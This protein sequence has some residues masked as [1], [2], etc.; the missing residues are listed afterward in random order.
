MRPAPPSTEPRCAVAPFGPKHAFRCLIMANRPLD[1]EEVRLLQAFADDVASGD[2]W[3]WRGVSG[4]RFTDEFSTRFL[5]VS[6]DL[7]ELARRDYVTR[8]DVLDPARKN[9]FYLIRI[10]G[11]GADY[12]AG[13]GGQVPPSLP[14]PGELTRVDLESLFIS[15]NSWE[16]LVALCEEL[17]ADDW[18]PAERIGTRI[19]STFHQN[20]GETL[21]A[22]GLAERRPIEGGASRV[23][24]GG[25]QYRATPLGRTARLVDGESSE[26][27]VQIRVTGLVRRTPSN[28]PER[29]SPFTR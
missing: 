10:S 14:E 20:D 23:P 25:R 26:T 29:R 19:G 17:D 24:R 7:Q 4:W 3:T 21:I 1:P 2:G 5:L 18:V 12:L 22:R 28:T 13:C 11:R 27:R 15:R 9:A 6:E 16:G 8:D